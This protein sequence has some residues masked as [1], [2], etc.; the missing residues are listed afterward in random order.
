VPPAPLWPSCNVPFACPHLLYKF[1][2]LVWRRPEAPCCRLLVTL[3]LRCHSITRPAGHSIADT[4]GSHRCIPCNTNEVPYDENRSMDSIAPKSTTCLEVFNNQETYRTWSKIAVF[5][6][7][8]SAC[9]HT[10]A[11][12]AATC[13]VLASSLEHQE[14]PDM[15]HAKYM[16]AALI[17]GH[18]RRTLH[19]IVVQAR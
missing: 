5:S 13:C 16:A 8:S 3:L 14:M 17:N 4:D 10:Q 15:Q 18:Q 9:F 2:I 11:Y 6:S 12:S 1:E 19:G 7:C